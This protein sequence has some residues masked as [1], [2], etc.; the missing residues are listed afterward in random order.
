[1]N[2]SIVMIV[3]LKSMPNG[4]LHC[5]CILLAQIFANKP[6]IPEGTWPLSKNGNLGALWVFILRHK[7]GPS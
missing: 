4:F 2:M 1:M 7:T 5:I 3:V 6:S